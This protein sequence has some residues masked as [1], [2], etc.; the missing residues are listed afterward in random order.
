MWD[1]GNRKRTLRDKHSKK[2][3][4]TNF[5]DVLRDIYFKFFPTNL[6]SKK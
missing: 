6:A 1:N 4:N 2:V 3:R 5:L